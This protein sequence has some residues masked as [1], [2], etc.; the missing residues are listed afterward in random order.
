M[1][2]QNLCVKFPWLCHLQ[3]V[4]D[5][6]IDTLFKKEEHYA[7]SWK[8][9]GG[10]GAFMMMC[11]KW[12]RIEKL[13]EEGGYDIFEV[14][15]DNVGDVSDDIDDL[16]GYLLLIKAQQAMKVPGA[17]PVVPEH[18]SSVP[19]PAK[20]S[21]TLQLP[22]LGELMTHGER[23]PASI[24]VEEDSARMLMRLGIVKM[25]DYGEGGFLLTPVRETEVALGDYQK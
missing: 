22:W 9:R 12:D 21:Y 24:V 1:N 14:L 20:K 11:R 25:N 10:V 17:K 6:V 7:G 23:G 15:H 4:A 13:A 5:A 2:K 18:P 3:P 19:L 16:I 8:K